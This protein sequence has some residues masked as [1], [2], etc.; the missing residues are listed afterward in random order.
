MIH[1]P[2]DVVVLLGSTREGRFGPTVARWFMTQAGTRD[3]ITAELIDLADIGLP[4]H[5]PSRHGDEIA[6]YVDRIDRADAYVVVT[7]EYNHGYPASL[8]MAID[9]PHAEWRNKPVGF[10]SCG[11]MAGGL[12]A[13]EQLRLVFAE[14]HV[15]TMRDCVSFHLAGGRFDHN[16]DPYDAD[17]CNGA[18]ATMLDQLV[19][20]GRALRRAR[21]DPVEAC[22][23]D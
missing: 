6:R 22:R 18:A 19:W 8:K 11:G 3:D 17:G 2:L 5:H 1:D 16:G 4:A 10:V 21:H 12:R 7:P 13:V 20:W 14:L 23:V 9:L 15:V